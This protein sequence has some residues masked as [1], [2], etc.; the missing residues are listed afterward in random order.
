MTKHVPLSTLQQIPLF[1]GLN[2]TEL[3]Q[4][5]EIAQPKEFAPGEVIICQGQRSQELWLLMEGKCEVIK[6]VE[7]PE[8]GDSVLLAV[9]GPESYFGEMSFFHSAP[10]SASVRAKTPVKLLKVIRGDYEELIQEGC[11]AAYKLAYN[12][13]ESLSEKLRKM[14]AWV[15][16]LMA[17]AADG[18]IK[19]SPPSES[20]G[21]SQELQELREKMPTSWNV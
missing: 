6:S 8:T 16:T 10:H 5:A 2:E 1:R 19:V 21:Q 20:N 18:K 7:E 4:V 14:D 3:R 9:L 11:R 17:S 13:V 15:A 12:T